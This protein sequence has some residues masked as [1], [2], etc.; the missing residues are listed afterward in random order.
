[1]E[2]AVQYGFRKNCGTNTAL[3]EIVD[4]LYCDLNAGKKCTGLFMD[5]SKAFDCVDHGI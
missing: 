3:S 4:M 5:L 2:I 1:M